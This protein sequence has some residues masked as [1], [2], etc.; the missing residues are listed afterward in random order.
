MALDIC[1]SAFDTKGLGYVWQIILS[2]LANP[3]LDDLRPT[4]F[5]FAPATRTTA[6]AP[7]SHFSW[8]LVPDAKEAKMSW[9]EGGDFELLTSTN[10]T[11]LDWLSEHSWEIV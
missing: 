4:A 9:L 10:S 8:E 7:S 5:N 1:F 2:Y 6:P 3:D 11:V